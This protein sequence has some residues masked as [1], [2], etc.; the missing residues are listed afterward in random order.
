M[1]G[2]ETLWLVSLYVISLY[3]FN[4]NIPLEIGARILTR[5][6][7]HNNINLR[8]VYPYIDH[9][10]DDV[11]FWKVRVCKLYCMPIV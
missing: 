9:W 6:V 3:F 10:R 2:I 4:K 5:I 7:Q 8:D 11:L 1:I